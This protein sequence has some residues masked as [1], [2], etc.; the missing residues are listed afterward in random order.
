MAEIL[1]HVSEAAH[2]TAPAL[3]LSVPIIDYSVH[4]AGI[5]LFLAKLAI[6]LEPDSDLEH[7]EL[8]TA[9]AQLTTAVC[10]PR[11]SHALPMHQ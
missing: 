8:T 2:I 11:V 5:D 3:E 6:Q 9:S 10:H 1:H 7:T 4:H